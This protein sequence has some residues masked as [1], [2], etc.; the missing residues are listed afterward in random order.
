MFP[1]IYPYDI[2]M[3]IGFTILDFFGLCTKIELNI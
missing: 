2:V 1:P 3:L